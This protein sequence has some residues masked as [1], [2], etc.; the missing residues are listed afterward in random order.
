MTQPW[1]AP[2]VAAVLSVT[3]GVGTAAAQT[4]MARHVPA[5]EQVEVML[6]GKA[7]GSA[8]A[9][10]DGNAK[11]P[12][13]LQ[14]A[15]GKSEID[16]NIYV[17]R[18]ETKHR[19]W[20]VEVGGSLPAEGTCD[21]R[22][23]SGVYWVRTVSTIVVNDVTATTPTL[24]LI[25]GSYTPPAPG[26]ENKPAP[27]RE[28]PAG[29]VLFGGAGL[30]KM[31][32]V[33][34][35]QCGDLTSCS[36]HERGFGLTAG[37]EYRFNGVLSAEASYVKPHTVSVTG[38][39]DTYHFTTEQQAHVFTL[40]GK[41]GVPINGVAKLYG[42]GGAVYNQAK[43]VTT[44]TVTDRTVTVD[45]VDQTIPGG[46]QSIE[47]KT[48]GWGWLFGGGL[49]V[50]VSR[51]IGIYGEFDYSSLKGDDVNGGDAKIDNHVASMLV[52][53]RVHLGK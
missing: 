4:V 3:I 27:K 14:N 41:L 42:R 31:S 17:D 5:G 2:I 47:F 48:D 32:N 52:G 7:V 43:V 6:N 45:G 8:A 24:L 36:G 28:L 51:S 34:A 29:L 33:T 40:T 35:V 23:V 18:C 26:E 49:E 1:R 25:K 16:A 53:L 37:G 39:G 38:S 10:A 13:N 30:T 21:L 22:T 9:D 46:T 20:I 15:L 12:F 50:W 19:V 44:Q 11:V